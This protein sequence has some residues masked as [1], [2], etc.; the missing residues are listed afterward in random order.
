MTYLFINRRYLPPLQLHNPGSPNPPSSGEIAGSATHVVAALGALT[1]DLESILQD[2]SSFEEKITIPAPV[3]IPAICRH[4]DRSVTQE[5]AIHALST[6][7]TI[8]SLVGTDSFARAVYSCEMKADGLNEKSVIESILQLLERNSSSSQVISSQVF[9]ARA[10]FYL[11]D[12]K[13]ITR[14]LSGEDST[15]SSSNGGAAEFYAEIANQNE[16]SKLS[17]PVL[18][19][20]IDEVTIASKLDVHRALRNVLDHS[21]ASGTPSLQRWAAASIRHL[22]IEDKR[23]VI[24]NSSYNSFIPQISSTG[25]ILILCSMMGTSDSD[26][27]THATAALASIVV[28]ARAIDNHRKAQSNKR[29]D[30]VLISS[31]VD[32]DGCGSSLS[33]IMQSKDDTVARMGVSFAASLISPLLVPIIVKNNPI[34]NDNRAYHNAALA[35]ANNDKCLNA[36][37]QIVQNNG[38]RSTELI[39]AAVETLASIAIACCSKSNDPMHISNV[40]TAIAK[41]ESMNISEAILNVLRSSQSILS[42]DS[43]SAQLREAAGILTCALCYTTQET[44][45]A[46]LSKRSIST[47]LSVASDESM[48]RPSQLRCQKALRCLPL[49]EAVSAILVRNGKGTSS[50]DQPSD[51]DNLLEAI[52]GGIIPLVSR[53]MLAKIDFN[54]EKSVGDISLKTVSCL[55]IDSIFSIA[56]YDETLIGG[57]RLYG[58][59]LADAETGYRGRGN[60]ISTTISLLHAS[61]LHIQQQG[62]GINWFGDVRTESDDTLITLE[63]SALLAVGSI[64]G[65]VSSVRARNPMYINEIDDQDT[66]AVIM[67]PKRF[68][69]HRHD[70]CI[71]SCGILFDGIDSSIF[72]TMLVGALG[73]GAILPTLRLLAALCSNGP[74]DLYPK[75]ANNGILI[76]ISDLLRNAMNGKFECL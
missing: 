49:L 29:L 35:L 61:T 72:A 14:M 40:D 5:H 52:E 37:V 10:L 12:P 42:Q 69:E 9:A 7:L 15:S 8:G 31:I 2:S 39:R 74:E 65:A 57:S 4:I 51:L 24:Q 48:Q 68:T 38:S 26:T 20:E 56:F 1:S 25:G 47:L 60:L 75:L 17:E 53:L 30:R 33:Q 62:G 76:P 43:P 34:S 64:C 32:A 22:I 13:I 18:V 11:T 50:I 23:R 55:I 19:K 66:D 45:N 16:N 59:I 70:A 6:L 67:A 54:S 46:L 63:E 58:A 21:S 73:E 71:A 41:L 44:M 27:R 3:L 28:S 36:L